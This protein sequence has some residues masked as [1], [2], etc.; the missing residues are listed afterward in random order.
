MHRSARLVVPMAVLALVLPLPALLGWNYPLVL[1]FAWH[2]TLHVLGAV[3]FLGNIA[4]GALW[5]AFAVASREPCTVRFA[6]STINWSD[7][8]FTGPGVL[9]VMYNGLVMAGSLGGVGANR[10]TQWGLAMFYGVI[11]AW[12]LSVVPDQHRILALADEA[13]APGPQLRKAVLRWNVIG[14]VAG[15]LAV[16]VLI[17]MVLKP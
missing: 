12:I 7:A 17:L 16:A 5:G 11:L 10:F 8:A 3:L 15:V 4:T 13:A 1:P 2:K 9:L 6:L 14:S